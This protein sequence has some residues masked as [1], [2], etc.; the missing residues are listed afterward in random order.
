MNRLI[1]YDWNWIIMI[2]EIAATEMPAANKCLHIKY[3]TIF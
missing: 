2:I 1:I 3:K